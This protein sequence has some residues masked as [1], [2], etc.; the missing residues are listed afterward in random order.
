MGAVENAGGWELVWAEEFDVPGKPDPAKWDYEIGLVRNNEA[1]FYTDAEENCRVE[2]SCLVIT[3]KRQ[4]TEGKP[5]SPDNLADLSSKKGEYTSA[6]IFSKESFL[7]G[8]IEA[9]A[10]IPTGKGSWPAIWMLGEN[11]REV[12][13]PLCGEIDI[14]ENVGKEPNKIHGTMH[15]YSWLNNVKESTGEALEADKPY[16]DFHIYAVEWDSEKAVF[17]YDGKP[18]FTFKHEKVGNDK[19]N[20]FHKPHFLLL[21]LAI[22]GSWGGEIDESIFPLKYYIDY[23][24]VYR[25]Q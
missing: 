21:N 2:D 20:P 15:Y 8:R 13:W 14:M 11:I 24:R 3:A 1:Q 6:S 9:R 25:K 18:Y 7:Y 4:E 22:G 19:E 16:E 23:V 17:S 12:G 5:S 10:K